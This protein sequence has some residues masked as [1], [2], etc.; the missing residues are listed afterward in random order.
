MPFFKS[1]TKVLLFSEICKI[2]IIF[3]KIIAPLRK[4]RLIA[5]QF[6]RESTKEDKLNDVPNQSDEGFFVYVAMLNMLYS[7]LSFHL[8]CF[9]SAIFCVKIHINL[10]NNKKSVTF[11]PKPKFVSA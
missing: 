2:L 4:R 7:L 5:Y 11:A 10:Y 6:Y 3:I 1:G 8:M 9:I